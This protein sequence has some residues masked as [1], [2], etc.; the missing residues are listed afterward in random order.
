[1][2]SGLERKCCFCMLDSRIT[3]I[4]Q[5][6]I[7]YG[8]ENLQAKGQL[9]KAIRQINLKGSLY[10]PGVI[11]FLYFSEE[12]FIS[13]TQEVL[14]SEMFWQ[15]VENVSLNVLVIIV[16]FREWIV[17]RKISCHDLVKRL[18]D[19]PTLSHRKPASSSLMRGFLFVCFVLGTPLCNNYLSFLQHVTI[20]CLFPTLTLSLL[21]VSPLMALL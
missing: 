4:S 1:M 16:N 19:E 14:W 11:W 17:L 10:L 8:T 9:K 20:A 7:L 6:S 21:K 12:I 5:K 13:L 3:S 2:Q 18:T 15:L